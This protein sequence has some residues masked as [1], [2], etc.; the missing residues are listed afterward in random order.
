MLKKK[1]FEGALIPGANHSPVIYY[2]IDPE[3]FKKTVLNLDVKDRTANPAA[4]GLLG[5][6]LTTF[7]LNL[8]NAGVYPMNSMILAMGFCYGG[9]AQIFAG[10][11]EFTK[12]NMFPMIAFVSYGFFWWSLVFT[13]VYP[14]VTSKS[15]TNPEGMACYMFIWGVFSTCMFVATLK[16][17]P[18]AL[19][20]VFF[21]VVLL[22][23]LL[24]AHF[25][26]E[27]EDV[28]KAAGIEGIIC[29]L[30]AIYTAFGEILN[31][32]YGRTILPLGIRNPQPTKK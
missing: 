19:V 23:F 28:L 8:H 22:F 24:A 27:S 11:F 16:K 17:A 10:V 25:W 13:I 29:G 21:T 18:W 31:D 14:A 4:L 12:G 5:F 20:F 32:T 15:A 7:L 3:S 30:S 2:V 6:G 1:V 26:S 9:A